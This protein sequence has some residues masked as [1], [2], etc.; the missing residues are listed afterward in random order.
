MDTQQIIEI[1]AYV[2]A[3]AS[4]LVPVLYKVAE[5][6]N[7]K[8]DDKAVTVLDKIVKGS[9][10]IAEALGINLLAKAQENK[11]KEKEDKTQ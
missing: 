4:A 8:T 10:K 5:I 1:I 9:I 11:K 3:G 2:V 7:T 6:T